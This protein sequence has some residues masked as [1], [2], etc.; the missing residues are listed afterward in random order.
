MSTKGQHDTSPTTIH[1]TAPLNVQMSNR[2]LYGEVSGAEEALR[3][4]VEGMD[5]EVREAEQWN[6][7][8]GE[9]EQQYRWP[10]DLYTTYRSAARQA[11]A[12]WHEEQR[13][14]QERAIERIRALGER[15]PD[16][17]TIADALEAEAW[18][19]LAW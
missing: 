5:A 15:L 14:A 12:I 19:G 2:L 13:A 17:T 16:A 11:L 6:A 1:T 7:A 10:T 4:V 8:L 18:D 3:C 9:H